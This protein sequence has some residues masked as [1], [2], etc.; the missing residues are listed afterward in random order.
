VQRGSPQ[1]RAAQFYSCLFYGSELLLGDAALGR[2]QAACF[3]K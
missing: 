2:L 3:G 1:R